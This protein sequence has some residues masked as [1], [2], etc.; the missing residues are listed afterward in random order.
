MDST[1][2]FHDKAPGA[3]EAVSSIVVVLAAVDALCRRSGGLSSLSKNIAVAL[4]QADEWGFAGSRRFAQDVSSSYSCEKST[5]SSRDGSGACLKPAAPSLAFRDLSLSQVLAVDQVG[6]G[7]SLTAIY[8]SS[9]TTPSTLLS[10]LTSAATATTAVSYATSATTTALPPSPLTSLLKANSSLSGLVLA[11]YSSTFS[12]PRYHS[13]MD[14]WP[15]LNTT[16]LADVTTFV[17]RAV[18][19]AA[20]GADADL[21]S[22]SANA[23]LV[24]E[25]VS[26]L[27]QDWNCKQLMR[28]YIQSETDS[29]FDYLG[30][31]TYLPDVPT[32]PSFYSSIIASYQ[33]LPLVQVGSGK[34]GGVSDLYASWDGD[35]DASRG[36]KVYVVPKPLEA[37][38][39]AFLAATISQAD[40]S[41]FQGGSC[42]KAAD[43][44]DGTCDGGLSTLEC[45][46]GQ[47]VCRS[48][49]FYHTALD[50][51]LRP[52]QTP[53]Q[54]EV[55]DASSPNWA[56]PN[57]VTIGMSVWPDTSPDVENAAISVGV[58]VLVFSTL[59]A[60]WFQTYL[61]K[62]SIF[63]RSH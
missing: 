22:I 13:H 46:S 60:Y 10:G 47:C 11:G 7:S 41:S 4:F 42:K 55:V 53:D 58:V 8:A 40:T 12:D 63:E 56:E 14:E 37:F 44:G 32:T 45:V 54:F 26:C 24:K 29:L 27:T 23:T 1:S 38:T 50:P 34:K 19:S 52:S 30:R 48:L 51:G 36:D 6:L 57:W 25:L 62:H 35:F 31:S 9:Q 20:G 21:S 43:C 2:M 16:S 33:G 5:T 15:F 39:R 61:T 49:A 59:A 17:A 3:N 18:Y 28:P